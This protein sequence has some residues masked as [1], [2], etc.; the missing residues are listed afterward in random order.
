MWKHA[1]AFTKWVPSNQFMYANL[2]YNADTM[3]LERFG[4]IGMDRRCFWGAIG[5][6]WKRPLPVDQILPNITS[7]VEPKPEPKPK[8]EY[9]IFEIQSLTKVP[10]GQTNDIEIVKGEGEDGKDTFHYQFKKRVD[11][12]Y[13]QHWW[14]YE[15]NTDIFVIQAESAKNVWFGVED[16][17]IHPA[18]VAV[19]IRDDLTGRF[20]AEKIY[21]EVAKEPKYQFKKV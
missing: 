16:D 15:V 6:L 4:F 18:F 20:A 8:L 10:E 21:K 9:D 12:L 1:C 13:Q 2:D 5:V 17:G 3:T 19:V 14:F 7:I 11:N